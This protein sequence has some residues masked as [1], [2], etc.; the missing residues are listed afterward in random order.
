[1]EHNQIKKITSQYYQK[2]RKYVSRIP[3]DFDISTIHEFRVEYKKLRAFFRMLSQQPQ[4]KHEISVSKKL[5]TVYALSGSLR[6]LQLQQVRVSDSTR[7]EPKQP[8]AYLHLLQKK[9][10]ILKTQLTEAIAEKPVNE[11]KRKTDA[12]S[13]ERFKSS[14]FSLF[15]QNR[16]DAIKEIIISGDFSDQNIHVI[17]KMLKD[18]FYIGKISEGAGEK[19]QSEI[20]ADFS[21]VNKLLDELGDFQDRCTSI[22]LL[23]SYWIINLNTYNQQLLNRL[24]KTWIRQKVSLKQMLIRKIKTELLS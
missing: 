18:L 16:R 9:I 12:H 7:K 20:T 10:E 5:K 2:L 14:G 15:V 6:D 13:P 22:A 1:M 3:D 8:Q 23:K 4:I 17:R 24:K 11:S 19:N 21:N